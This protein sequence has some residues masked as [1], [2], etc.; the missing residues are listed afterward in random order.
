MKV[1]RWI[2]DFAKIFVFILICFLGFSP[3]SVSAKSIT[4]RYAN[5]FPP[6]HARMLSKPPKKYRGRHGISF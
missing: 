3:L 5:F 1:N 4:L 6:T 2:D